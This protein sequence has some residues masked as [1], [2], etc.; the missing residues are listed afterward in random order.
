M[1]LNPEFQIGEMV[2]ISDLVYDNPSDLE[3]LIIDYM[4]TIDEVDGSNTFA[5]DLITEKLGYELRITE[6][7]LERL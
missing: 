3:A 2:K 4:T 5:Y 1:Q 6:R 7:F